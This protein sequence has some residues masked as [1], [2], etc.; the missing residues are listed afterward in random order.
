M[1]TDYGNSIYVYLSTKGKKYSFES[2]Y[3]STYHQPWYDVSNWNSFPVF[4]T[5]LNFNI[6]KQLAL[7]LPDK[8]YLKRTFDFQSL[9]YPYIKWYLKRRNILFESY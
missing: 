1:L 3:P 4:K 7:I 2:K 5:I 6:N 8:F 9:T